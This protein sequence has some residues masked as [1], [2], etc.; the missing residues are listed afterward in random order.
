MKGKRF[1]LR[2]GESFMVV[3]VLVILVVVALLVVVVVLIEGIVWP[4]SYL[5]D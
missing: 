5:E 4:L 2:S 1:K 3:I